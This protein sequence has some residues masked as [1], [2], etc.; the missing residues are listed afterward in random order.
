MQ[1]IGDDAGL[2]RTSRELLKANPK[3]VRQRLI[4]G[5]AAARLGDMPTIAKLREDSRK[6]DPATL[7]MIETSEALVCARE[8]PLTE[9]QQISFAELA[10]ACLTL[11]PDHIDAHL[12]LATIARK[13]GDIKT[14]RKHLQTATVLSES[15][16]DAMRDRNRLAIAQFTPEELKGHFRSLTTDPRVSSARWRAATDFESAE[17]LAKVL[18]LIAPTLGQEPRSMLWIAQKMEGVGRPADAIV[19]LQQLTQRFPKYLD[20][21]VASLLTASRV[22]VDETNLVVAHA[23][24]TLD[25]QSFHLLCAEC[26][27]ALSR[28]IP[29]W[30]P[31]LESVAEF[32]AYAEACMIVCELRDR[33]EDALPVLKGLEA[34]KAASPDDV[35]WA[36]R[37]QA[38]IVAAK[39]SAAQKRQSIDI[40]QASGQTSGTGE[41]LDE[42]RSKLAVLLGTFRAATGENRRL[43]LKQMTEILERLTSGPKG[44]S[45]DWFHLAQLY[46]ATGDRVQTRRALE[47]IMKRDPKNLFFVAANVDDL[48]SESQY[49]AAKPYVE[50]LIPGIHDIRVAGAACRYYTLINQPQAALDIVEKFVHTVDAGTPDGMLKQR[51]SAELLDNLTR[52]ASSKGLSGSKALI[53]GACERYKSSLKG[54]PEA[55]GPMAALLAYDG[56]VQVAFDEL[57]RYKGNLSANALAVAGVSILRSGHA[58]TRQF[59]TVKAWLEAA[60]ANEPESMAMKLN[61][62]ELHALRQ[63]FNT[64]E[65]IYREI[66]KADAKNLVALNNLAWILAPRS[67]TAEQALK[68]ADKAIELH[69]ATGEMLDTRARILISAGKFDQAVHDLQD[70]IGQAPTALRYFHLALAKLKMSKPE[71]AKQIFK[72]AKARGLDPKSIH[73]SD[74]PTFKILEGQQQ[75]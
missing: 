43:V 8:K 34:L 1:L 51:Q 21:W 75:G 11:S 20:G 46:R 54:Y 49:D 62:G 7:K 42:D 33:L 31:P 56:Q 64:A 27:S 57:E 72:E 22:G 41:S 14:A 47:E 74:L 38:G 73:P 50:Q 71:E 18:P 45:N 60:L 15:N 48:L 66:L 37:M 26:G 58:T 59:Q 55:I 35:A 36:K 65:Q 68:Y 70:A 4:L 16:L 13:R 40:L 32:R 2:M 3:N 53:A 5:S 29:G 25:K 28:K 17:E 12:L 19:L 69:G 61:L 6:L 10:K 44:T 52:L 39:G 30:S 23:A 24:K 63:D 9:K 67:D